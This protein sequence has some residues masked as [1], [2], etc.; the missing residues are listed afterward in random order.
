[1][2][3][4]IPESFLSLN[5]IKSCPANSTDPADALSSPPMMLRSVDFP[6]P[7]RPDHSH[8]LAGVNADVD[9][10]EGGQR[11]RTR[12][13][14]GNTSEVKHRFSGNEGPHDGYLGTT[15]TSPAAISPLTSTRPST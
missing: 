14:L 7:R 5:S 9:S 6:D 8:R 10:I 4:R 15:T 11:R 2:T 13:D 3:A 12:I 1:M